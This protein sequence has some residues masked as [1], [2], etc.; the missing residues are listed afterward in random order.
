MAKL[1][2]PEKSWVNELYRNLYVKNHIRIKKSQVLRY[3]RQTFLKLCFQP[4]DA[5][6]AATTVIPTPL[7][8]TPPSESMSPTPPTPGQYDHTTGVVYIDDH[9]RQNHQQQ[10]KLFIGGLHWK[11]HDDD[12]REYFSTYGVVTDAMVCVQGARI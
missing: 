1:F 9:D 4:V 12:L 8:P 11:T 2:N 5:P 3:I 10:K 6:Q 7:I